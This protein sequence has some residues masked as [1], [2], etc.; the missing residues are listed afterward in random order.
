MGMLDLDQFPALRV[1]NAIATNICIR[2]GGIRL[3]GNSLYLPPPGQA[4]QSHANMAR[5][6]LARLS[7]ALFS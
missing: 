1:K 5:L 2:V 4:R 3:M 6:G 7:Q